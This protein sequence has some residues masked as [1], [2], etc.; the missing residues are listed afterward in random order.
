LSKQ[1]ISLEKDSWNFRNHPDL[2]QPAIFASAG[3]QKAFTLHG[4]DNLRLKET[5]RI[6]A[7]ENELQ[8]MGVKAKT[9]GY[10]MSLTPQ[11]LVSPESFFESYDDHRMVMSIAP[12]SLLFDEIRIENPMV[13]AK[14]Y[15]G[16]WK[17]VEKFID[18]RP[19]R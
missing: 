18:V 2:V 15:P 13:V 8:R 11:P 17:Q 4:L 7:I 3:L 14:S 16:F 6:A 10:S 5:D 12:M 9:E 19:I 1:K